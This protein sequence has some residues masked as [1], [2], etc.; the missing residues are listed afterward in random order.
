MCGACGSYGICH[1]ALSF[2]DC[3]RPCRAWGGSGAP[4]KKEG[5][6]EEEDSDMRGELNPEEREALE[7]L[8]SEQ[9]DALKDGGICPLC[10]CMRPLSCHVA[11]REVLEHSR[12][13]GCMTCADRSIFAAEKE[14]PYSLRTQIFLSVQSASLVLDGPN[15]EQ[16]SH[17]NMAFI[18]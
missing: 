10:P 9:A 3:Q 4:A 12:F 8:V 7:G 11:W 18:S 17:N 13:C 2:A 14:T 5:H 1:I 15:S 6:E 16:A